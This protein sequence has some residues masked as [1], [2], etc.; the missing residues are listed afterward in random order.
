[1]VDCGTYNIDTC[2]TKEKKK[3]MKKNEMKKEM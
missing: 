1:M 2:I 3:E